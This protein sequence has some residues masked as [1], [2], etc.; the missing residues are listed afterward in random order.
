MIESVIEATKMSPAQKVEKASI[1]TED[2]IEVEFSQQGI[3]DNTKD[4]LDSANKQKSEIV[5]ELVHPN[6]FSSESDDRSST[7]SELD[8]DGNDFREGMHA[9]NQ[10]TNNTRKVIEIVN[11]SSCH[12]AKRIITPQDPDQVPDPK[13]RKTD[14]K[15]DENLNQ[16]RQNVTKFSKKVMKIFDKIQSFAFF[17]NV[18]IMFL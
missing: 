12:Q 9:L 10:I 8:D 4:L 2:R 13:R 18:E 15:S 1:V 14:S 6:D 17:F 7:E 5:L 3:H 16:I 11:N